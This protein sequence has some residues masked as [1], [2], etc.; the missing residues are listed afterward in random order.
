MLAGAVTRYRRDALQDVSPGLNRQGRWRWQGTM[1]LE[2]QVDDEPMR[3]K[4]KATLTKHVRS[5]R[6]KISGTVE[7]FP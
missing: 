1:E 3:P 7:D 6:Q 2:L 4:R 5:N